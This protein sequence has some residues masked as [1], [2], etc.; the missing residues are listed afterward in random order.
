MAVREPRAREAAGRARGLPARRVERVAHDD[1]AIVCHRDEAAVERGVEVRREQNTVVDVEP[2]G[3]RLAVGPGLDVARAQERRHSEPGDG[4]APLPEVEEPVAKQVLSDA[5]DDEPL[6]LRRL[7]EARR[8]ASRTCEEARSA[9]VFQSWNARR[10]SR[11]SAGTSGTVRPPAAPFGIGAAIG[12][13]YSPRARATFCCE[14]AARKTASPKV[15]SQTR[16]GH[17]VLAKASQSPSR[18]S[19]WSKPLSDA[20]F[21]RRE[22]RMGES[23]VVTGRPHPKCRARAAL[24]VRVGFGCGA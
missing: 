14:N 2:L 6:G 3:V 5:L 24:P 8:P 15:P 4:A 7:R 1:R 19:S 17:C 23:A 13:P 11:C 12:V 18:A 20:A 10:R 9:S 21:S 16:S 22:T